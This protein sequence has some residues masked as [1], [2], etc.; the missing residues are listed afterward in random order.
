MLGADAEVRGNPKALVVADQEES[1][2][3]IHQ[4]QWTSSVQF[5][6]V[7]FSPVQFGCE[8]VR[9]TIPAPIATTF[10]VLFGYIISKLAW[11]SLSANSARAASGCLRNLQVGLCESC[12]VGP[13][14][15]DSGSCSW[16]VPFGHRLDFGPGERSEKKKERE[17]LAGMAPNGPLAPERETLRAQSFAWIFQ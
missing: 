14:V 5:S 13:E 15:A 1:S 9:A 8:F 7:R 6:S 16:L 12:K 3:F 10:L 4:V 17:R 2:E 11:L